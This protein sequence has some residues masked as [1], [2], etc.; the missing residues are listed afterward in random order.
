[1]YRSSFPRF[2]ALSIVFLFLCSLGLAAGTVELQRHRETGV[3]WP[4]ETLTWTALWTNPDEDEAPAEVH[5][6]FLRGGRTEVAAGTIAWDAAGEA[7]LAVK[8]EQPDAMLLEVTWTDGDGE[9]HRV[10]SGGVVAPERIQPAV[11]AP[12]DFDAFWAEKIAELEAVPANP[13][14]TAVETDTEGVDYWHLTMDNIRGTHIN[15]QLARPQEGDQLPALL[16]VQWAGVYGLQPSWA[17]DRAK[18]G[19][20]TLNILPHDLPIDEPEEFYADLKA[21]ALADYAGIGK[22]DRNESYFLRMYLSCYRAVEYL[23]SRPDWNGETLVV[24]GTSQGG[25]QTFVT[26]GLQPDITAALALV[27]AGADTLAPQ[28]GRASAFPSWYEKGEESDN[29]EAVWE[30]S[31]Y[32]DAANFA[33]RI[34]APMLIGVGLKD[35]VCPPATVY[36]AVNQVQ[37]Y[38]EVVV[39]PDSGHQN[40]NGSQEPYNRHAYQDWLPAL[41][42]GLLPPQK[43]TNSSARRAMLDVLGIESTR[44]GAD[45]NNPDAPNAVNYD[46]SKATRF[47]VL[48]NPLVTDDGRPVTSTDVWWQ[49]RRPEIVEHFERE[50]YGRVPADVPAVHWEVVSETADKV[51]DIAV[52]TKRLSGRLDNSAYPFLQPAIELTVKVP[53]AASGPVP[54]ILNFGFPDWL[55]ALFPRAPGPSWAE[56]V[57]AHGW[58][59]ASMVPTSFQADASGG[60]NQ[61][62]IGLTARGKLRAPDEWGALRAW[63]WGASRCLDYLETDPRIDASR[64][65]LEG[66]SRYGKAVA[67]AMAFDE[68]FAIGFVGSSGA[69]GAKILRRDFGERVENLAGDYSNHWMAGNFMKYAGPLDWDDMPVDAHELLALCAPRP[70]FLSAGSGK[71]EGQ[72]IDQRG[73]FVAAVE[74]GPVYE[75]LGQR[76]LG[77]A[78]YPAEGEALIEGDI[79]WR[80][81]HGGHTTLPNWPTFFEWA[82]RYFEAPNN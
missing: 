54:A 82:D 18:E 79:A 78:E 32:Y 50:I 60:I 3:Y 49:Q 46:E 47:P 62:V 41:R 61:G 7:E 72:W 31:R 1:M 73:M 71:V 64:V 29:P 76:S 80:Q 15:G 51:G 26:A 45:P 69:G 16:I 44:P 33:A 75:L 55:V 57:L 8:L 24:M 20:L 38:T 42:R 74:A 12:E 52:V 53:A 34:K 4:N 37:G 35:V 19:W 48:P 25:Q 43:F 10:R 68:R 59:A 30:T 21:G 9:E 56:Q 58:A 14:L 36:A 65:A 40:V 5:Y 77:T 39:L 63:G 6:R 17:I 22:A 70:I 11:A 23:R 67:V 66:L 81:H 27:P 2:G 13:R 28:A